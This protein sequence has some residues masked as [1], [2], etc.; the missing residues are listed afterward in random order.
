MDEMMSQHRAEMGQIQTRILHE[1]QNLTNQLLGIVSQWTT[2]PA[3]LSDHTSASNQYFSQMM[4]NLHH[5]NSLVHDDTRVEGENQDDQF[6]V[7]G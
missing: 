6:I 2:H 3:A 1:Q 7:D 5:V 4:Q